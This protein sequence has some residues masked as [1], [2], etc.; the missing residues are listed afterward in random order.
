M[1]LSMEPP[2]GCLR[3]C[4]LWTLPLTPRVTQVVVNK[5]RR[6]Q[7]NTTPKQCASPAPLGAGCGRAEIRARGPFFFKKNSTTRY[8]AGFGPRRSRRSVS[9]TFRVSRRRPTEPQG[10]RA[11]GPAS[12]RPAGGTALKPQETRNSLGPCS[13][14]AVFSALTA[15]CY[16]TYTSLT[17]RASVG[18]TLTE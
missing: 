18:A 7:A 5:L 8:R 9:P 14:K 17:E 16:T 11:A 15:Q 3:V 13:E 12:G 6:A 4:L 1:P 2:E 10:H